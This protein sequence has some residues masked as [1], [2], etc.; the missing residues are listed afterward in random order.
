[1]ER[2]E[3]L[4]WLGGGLAAAG[5]AQAADGANPPAHD[6]AAMM[7]ANAAPLLPRKYDGALP[8]YQACTQAAEVCIAHCQQLL[9]RGD[10]SVGTCLRTA[11]DT[12]V[13]CG[14][15]LKLAGLNSAFTPALARDSVAVMQACVEACKE[16]IA[17][18]A[19]CKACHDACLKAIDAAKGAA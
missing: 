17:H 19:E 6:H 16:H 11:L 5:A 7:L 13:V 1:M 4:A 12:D 9:A 2:R 10:A 14:A 18:H 3:L 15:V 8:A